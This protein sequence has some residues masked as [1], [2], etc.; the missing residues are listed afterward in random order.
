MKWVTWPVV[1]TLMCCFLQVIIFVSRSLIHCQSEP[2]PSDSWWTHSVRCISLNPTFP[3][4]MQLQA[5]AAC[6][7]VRTPKDKC[8]I[9]NLINFTVNLKWNYRR[10]TYLHFFN[11]TWNTYSRSTLHNL[12]GFYR[13][14]VRECLEWKEC[15]APFYSFI[16]FFV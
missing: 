15:Y 4:W 5:I 12:H 2:Y 13:C 14:G 1:S 3:V 16:L 8:D 11:I 7:S 6:P 9:N 10:N